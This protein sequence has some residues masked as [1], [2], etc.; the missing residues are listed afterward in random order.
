MS[1]LPPDARRVVRVGET[2]RARIGADVDEEIRFH[3]EMR[4]QE[5]IAGGVSA[6]AAAKQAE[7]EFGD[8]GA[9]RSAL[10]ADDERARRRRSVRDALVDLGR[11]V[12]IAGCG[13]LRARLFAVVAVATLA[14]GI[15]A[16]A[17]LFGVV[18]GVILKPLPYPAPEQLVAVAPDHS[19]MRAEYTLARERMTT[20][21][22]VGGYVPGV[23]VGVAGRGDPVRLMAARTSWNL[24]DVLGVRP[25][26]GRG[27]E[28][29]HERTGAE[30]V[31]VLSHGLWQEWFGGGEVLGELLHIDGLDHVIIGVMP[32]GFTFPQAE[33]RLWLPLEL[34]AANPGTYWGIGGT[35]AVGRLRPGV[36]PEQVRDELIALAVEMRRANP[37]WTPR[38]PYRAE[39]TV[40]PLAEHQTG[41]SRGMLLLLLGATGFV[42]L[43]ACAN[44]ANLFLVRTI[45]REH[46]LAVRAALGGGRGT[47]LRGV[48]LEG[49]LLALVG[50]VLGV[51]LGAALL[52][53]L[54]PLLPPDTPRLDAVAMDGRVLLFA[55]AASLFAALVFSLLPAL[56]L[57]GLRSALTLRSG[58][59]N[60]GDGRASR[61]LSRVVVAGE[62]SLAVVLLLG[63]T[64][65]LRSLLELQAVDPGFRTSG[66]VAARV[67]PAERTLPDATAR[68]GFHDR[69][70]DRVAARPGIE[71]AAL[72]GQLPF[73]GE[74]SLVAAAV[75][76]VTT[77]P[78]ELPVFEYR[79]ITPDYFT[80]MG[81]P[82]LAGRGFDERDRIGSEPVAIVD[83]AAAA[84]FWPG[85]SALGKRIGRPWL[86]E[87]LT[88]VGVVPTVRNNELTGETG[89][90]FY[91]P[92]A[93]QPTVAATLVVRSQLPIGSVADAMR[94]AVH[95]TDPTVPLGRVRS[96]D[97]LVRDAASG[98]RAIAVLLSAFAAIALVLGA[99][100]IYG[101]LA[102]SV[103]QRAREMGVRLALGATTREVRMLVLRD[104]A[105]LL[106]GGLALGV[107]LALLLGRLLRGMLYGVSTTDPV[108]LLIAP[109]VLALAG[110]AAAYLPA[111][112]ASRVEPAVTLRE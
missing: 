7:R 68:L 46:D 87:W 37:F 14:I 43:I 104:G 108:S 54:L 19:F 9:A 66:V 3:I 33:T 74:L 39:N 2:D 50:G 111:L 64:L 90:A 10:I 105:L 45:G 32:R 41:E 8:V 60:A 36:Q 27:F 1:S 23:G 82:L 4:T 71:A 89:L 20:L 52:R 15:G 29:A 38:E 88:V 35:R 55:A 70:L 67:L 83:E 76:H 34:D 12:R 102:Y 69:V 22:D 25:A 6:A 75:E 94:D 21:E 17:A 56:R 57:S 18:D 30:R 48:A 86:N 63:S 31:V 112:R 65:L 92:F 59:R 26:L 107:P 103:Q 42:L 106:A 61:R 5:L 44:V 101:V 13:L 73:D 110:L 93:Q 53:G 49:L 91:V 98:P 51:L 109:A 97:A 100:G 99:L 78:N 16:N 79:P 96:I 77:D 85:E 58:A 62:V 80:I 40:V 95:G 47:I 11:D 72:T 84:R 81:M 28:A 24:F